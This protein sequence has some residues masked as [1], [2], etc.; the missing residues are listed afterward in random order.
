[1]EPGFRVRNRFGTRFRNVFQQV[2]TT[3]L[4]A[5]L[6]TEPGIKYIRLFWVPKFGILVLSLVCLQVSWTVAFWICRG[7][8]PVGRFLSPVK[9]EGMSVFRLF[10]QSENPLSKPSQTVQAI[11]PVS[12]YV[13]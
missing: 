10:R 1:M 7:T 6:Q 4:Q 3:L 11:Q 12:T 5:H 2:R 8:P 9:I 13:S